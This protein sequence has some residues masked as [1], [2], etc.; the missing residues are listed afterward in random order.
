MSVR[1]DNATGSGRPAVTIVS[2]K[3]YKTA[4]RARK[5]AMVYK[6]FADVTLL[7]L[8]AA[9]RSGA[10]DEPGEFD[11]DGVRVV[12]ADVGTLRQDPTLRNHALNIL[13]GYAPGFGRLAWTLFSRKRDVVHTTG[14]PLFVLGWLDSKLYGTK[15]VADVTERPAAAPVGVSLM[16]VFS[17]IEPFALGLARD[18]AHTVISVC[19]GHADILRDR[20]GIEAPMSVRNAPTRDWVCTDAVRPREAGSPL[21]LGIVSSI[22]ES[23]GFE[24]AIQAVAIARRRGVDVTLD[25]YG[26][27]RESYIGQLEDLAQREGV[28]DFVAFRGLVDS[29]KVSATYQQFDLALALYEATNEANDS[30]SNK[31]IEAVASGVPVLAGNLSENRRF[32]A[33][34][35]AGWAVPVTA[36]AIGEFVAN[37]TEPELASKQA[38]AQREAPLLRW[39]TEFLPVAERVVR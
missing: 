1:T 30:L 16:S 3:P 17:R 18:R 10:V 32:L 35:D 28:A 31:I 5:S 21:R 2:L 22:F 11:R 14:A 13:T 12:Q 19:A 20:F 24:Q 37:L 34:H 33:E 36:E 9:G 26:P 23:R 38:S 39:E 6:E 27:G 25:V 8:S 7:T 15:W 4:T 29:N